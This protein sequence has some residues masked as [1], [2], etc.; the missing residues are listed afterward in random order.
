MNSDLQQIVLDAT[1][2]DVVTD[3]QVIQTLWSGYGEIVRLLLLG[4]TVD[5]AIVKYI[6]IP[7]EI[8]HPRGW[9]TDRSHARKIRSYDVEM[10]W[11]R[12]WSE[13]CSE[14][15]RVADCYS[16]GSNGNEHVIVL[17]DLDA[18]GFPLRKSQLNK[19]EVKLCLQWLA[20]F[21]AIFMG[22]VTRG[23]WP[24]GSYWH[25]ETRPDE[26]A[27]MEEG[28]LKQAASKIDALLN[29]AQ[30]KTLVHGDAKVANFCF[31]ED[32]KSVAAVDFQ[33]VGG[34]CGMKD[35]A[36]FLGSC[37]SEEVCEQWLDERLDEYFR[38]LRTAL[39]GDEK[40]IDVGALECEWRELFPL[41][42]VDFH[43]FL[44][45][46]L[47]DHWKVNDYSRRMATQVLAQ[48]NE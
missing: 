45:G 40:E 1:H 11:Y 46:W 38:E 31:A 3:R 9:N 25:L 22:E 27:V 24:I 14:A 8:A 20:N 30:Y 35:V 42:W 2:S 34:G 26:W 13:R 33:Y 19:Q 41:A 18:S 47:P 29:N 10:Q 44:L 39:K 7:D 32:G 17:E 37:L 5:S 48:L 4:G 15:C 6:V 23:L 36:Y 16:V 28:E 43:R 21:H 12:D